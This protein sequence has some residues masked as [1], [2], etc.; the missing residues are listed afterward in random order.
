MIQIITGIGQGLVLQAPNIATQTVLP[1]KEVSTG[2]AIMNLFNFL[3]ASL[4]VTVGQTLFEHGLVKRLQPIIPNLDPS[5]LSNVGATS[6][7]N[8]VPHDQLPAVLSAYNDSMRSI[9]YLAIGLA[10][11]VFVVSWGLEWKSVKRTQGSVEG[12]EKGQKE[13]VS[14]GRT[15]DDQHNQ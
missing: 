11:L 8:M 9:W 3:G 7:R 14:D 15:L 1:K 4:F 2:L 10:G 5:T 12:Q 6:I 13:E